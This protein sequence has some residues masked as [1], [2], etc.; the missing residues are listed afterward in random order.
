MKNK[1]FRSLA[2]LEEARKKFL[3]IIKETKESEK[4]DLEESV[5]RVSSRDIKAPRPSPHYDRAAMDGYAVKAKDTFG[6]SSSSPRRLKISR[7]VEVNDKEAYPISTGQELPSGADAILKIENTEKN[8]RG[9]IEVLSSVAPGEDVAKKGEDVEKNQVIVKSGTLIRPSH[10]SLLRNIGIEKIPLKKRP[11]VAICPTGEELVRPGEKPK[12]GMTIESNSLM[13]KNYVA[14]WGGKPEIYRHFT[15]EKE[16]LETKLNSFLKTDLIVTIGGSSVGKRDRLV[17]LVKEKGDIV[18]HG[19]A[20]KPGKPVALG[21]YESVPIICLPGYPV[22][23]LVDSFFFLKAALQKMLCIQ[24]QDF[25][26]E[27]RLSEKIHSRLGKT[28]ITRVKI[29]QDKA[30]P[31]R[32]G[33]SGILSSVTESDGFVLVDSSIEGLDKDSIVKVY[34]WQ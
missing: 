16:I 28:T 29:K 27:L 18:V 15:D 30:H 10:M 24:K 26:R 14:R 3:K 5:D 32:T 6:A 17:E 9:E 2:P 13:V 25:Y 22:A 33:G 4:I 12:P 19:V 23:T 8:E 31:I 1:G 11:E 20:I 21:T 34:P 7:Q